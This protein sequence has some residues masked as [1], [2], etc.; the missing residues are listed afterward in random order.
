MLQGIPWLF[1]D[2]LLAC[3]LLLVAVQHRQ[4]ALLRRRTNRIAFQVSQLNALVRTTPSVPDRD[5]VTERVPS[6]SYDETTI[7]T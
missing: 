2:L 4:M 1:A 7:I 6:M 5:T 3:I